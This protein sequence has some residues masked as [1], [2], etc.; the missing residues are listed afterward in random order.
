M[1]ADAMVVVGTSLQ[2]Y[3]AAS[4]LDYLPR[5][6]P[7][8]LLDPAPAAPSGRQVEIIAEKAAAGMPV[9]RDSLLRHFGFSAD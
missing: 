6:N 9:V 4:L 1:K 3:P 2:V 5:R 8:I 7:L